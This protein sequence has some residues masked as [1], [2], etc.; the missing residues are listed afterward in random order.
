M[1]TK[2]LNSAAAEYFSIMATIETLQ[3]E[4]EA[5]RDSMKAVMTDR[6]AEEIEGDG[7]RATWHT[8]KTSRFDNK[9]FKAEH[10]DLYAAYTVTGHGTRFTLNA[11]TA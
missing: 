1:S 9:R 11:I 5:I 7:W 2:E 3:A 10:G 4:A 6:G 8:T